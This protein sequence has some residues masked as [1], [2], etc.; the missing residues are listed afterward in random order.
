M[1]VEI[2]EVII[3][4]IL[5]DEDDAPT[6]AEGGTPAPSGSLE[7]ISPEELVEMAVEQVLRILQR[8]QHR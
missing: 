3:R 7:G 5:E 4:A 1:A 8:K 2:K 6:L